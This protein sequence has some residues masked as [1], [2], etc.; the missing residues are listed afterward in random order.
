MKFWEVEG[1]WADKGELQQKVYPNPIV[2][3]QDSTEPFAQE[4]E[5]RNFGGTCVK[6]MLHI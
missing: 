4:L 1:L 6:K 5:Q 3:H 2:Y